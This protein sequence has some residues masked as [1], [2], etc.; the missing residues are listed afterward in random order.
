MGKQ[1]EGQRKGG[2]RERGETK[3]ER[4]SGRLPTECGTSQGL[5]LTTLRS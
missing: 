2:E 5:N 3:R 1:G 4:I